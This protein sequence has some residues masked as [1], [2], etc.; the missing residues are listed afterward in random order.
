MLLSKGYSS[1]A[2][3]SHLVSLFL[4]VLRSSVGGNPSSHVGWGHDMKTHIS[5]WCCFRW[6]CF[7]TYRRSLPSTCYMRP[8][9][10]NFIHTPIGARAFSIWRSASCLPGRWELLVW[11]WEPYLER[12]SFESSYSLGTFVR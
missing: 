3:R 7:L 4:S 6:P 1:L 2:Q 8:L 5:R 9:S 12:L 11:R 10:T